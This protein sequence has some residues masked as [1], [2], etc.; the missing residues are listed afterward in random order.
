VAELIV[1]PVVMAGAAWADYGL[2]DSGD[3]RKLERYGPH[4]F[5]RPDR[6]ALWPPKLERSASAGQFVPGPGGSRRGLGTHGGAE[7]RPPG[8][9]ALTL[10]LVPGCG[11]V[12][13]HPPASRWFAT[14]AN[15]GLPE[16]PKGPLAGGPNPSIQ[17]P[18]AQ[19]LFGKQGC[20]PQLCYVDDIQS[21]SANE[22]T[23]NWNAALSQIA[24]WL[25]VQ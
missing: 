11:H 12:Y 15:P 24:G 17:V 2:I 9:T 22:I 19:E 4:R 3:G 21:W 1:S 23:I 5:I 16:P 10:R 6:Q 7:Y 13:S 18:A 25:Y 14:A 20:A 8:A